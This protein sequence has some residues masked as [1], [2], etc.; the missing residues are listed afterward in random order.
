VRKKIAVRTIVDKGC[1]G[2]G[3]ACPEGCFIAGVMA[4]RSILSYIG[5]AGDAGTAAILFATE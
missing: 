5:S 3:H 1:T 2:M 4:E